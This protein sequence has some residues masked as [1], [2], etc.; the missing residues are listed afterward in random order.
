M[1]LPVIRLL[2]FLARHRMLTPKYARL[3]LRYLWRRLFTVAGW[4]WQT[5]GLLFLGRSLA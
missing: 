1:R 3:L 5:N 4:R 2:R